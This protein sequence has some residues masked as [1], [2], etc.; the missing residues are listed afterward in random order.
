MESSL[1][2]D[3]LA[4]FATVG[5][6]TV[7]AKLGGGTMST[8]WKSEHRTSGRM[9]ALKQGALSKLTR[10]LKNSLDYKLNYLSTVNH[11]NIVRLLEVLLQ[12]GSAL[13]SLLT[14]ECCLQVLILSKCHLGLL[15]V[16]RILQA[17]SENLSLEDLYLADNA[18]L[19]K[20]NTLQYY[21]TV[22][23]CSKSMKTNQ[24]NV[25]LF[26]QDFMPEE[27]EAAQRG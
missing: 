14:N 10:A 19:D 3:V 18:N 21:S 15:G 27:F 1:T 13:V 12:G 23:E 5:D 9:V 8:V 4:E 11:P 26:F 16:L 6:Y 22:T 2:T 25:R 24:K 7:M 20:F 17:L